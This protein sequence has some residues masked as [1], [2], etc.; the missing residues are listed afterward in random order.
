LKNIALRELTIRTEEW[1]KRMGVRPT[2]ISVGNARKRWGSCKQ[3]GSVRYTW[4]IMLGNDRVVDYL[5]VHEL[6][7]LKQMN[8]SK[9]FWAVVGS[10]LPDFK[11]RRKEL[12]ALYRS[13]ENEGW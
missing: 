10:V 1:A 7:H 6:A 13:I 8:H 11:E 5:V 4:R 3:D 2:K 12:R 9:R